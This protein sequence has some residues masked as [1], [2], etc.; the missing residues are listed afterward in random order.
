MPKQPFAE[1]R[2]SAGLTIDETAKRLNVDRT[3]IIRWEKGSP[4][5]PLKR[6]DDAKEVL[7]ASKRDLRPDIF[8]AAE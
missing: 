7:G 4:C 3:T 8:E 2:K 1:F 6:L 5:I